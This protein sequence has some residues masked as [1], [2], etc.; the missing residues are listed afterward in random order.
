MPS[1]DPDL[2]GDQSFDLPPKISCWYWPGDF[3][4]AV[5]DWWHLNCGF[6]KMPVWL[7]DHFFHLFLSQLSI[8]ITISRD[9]ASC[10]WV[11]KNKNKG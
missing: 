11:S 7:G 9:R 5:K 3:G 4:L 10:D 1:A 8:A 2:L 6:K